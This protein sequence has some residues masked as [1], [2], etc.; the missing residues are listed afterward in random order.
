MRS[1]TVWRWFQI[2]NHYWT[3]PL[4]RNKDCPLQMSLNLVI[5]HPPPKKKKNKNKINQSW[6][7]QTKK[8]SDQETSHFT[9]MPICV[10]KKYMAP[11]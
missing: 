7:N 1:D 10:D 8:Y 5:K 11:M 9:S 2:Q 3:I 6:N 4:K